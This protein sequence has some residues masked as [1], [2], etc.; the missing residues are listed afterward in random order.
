MKLKYQISEKTRQKMKEGLKKAWKDGK[1][2]NVDWKAS[3]K[4]G[5]KKRIKTLNKHSVKNKISDSVTEAWKNG[6][7]SKRKSFFKKGDKHPFYNPD[8][9]KNIKNTVRKN[10]KACHFCS[11]PASIVHRLNPS[12][13]YT[14]ENC[15][16]LCRQCHI[17]LH[18]ILRHL[19]IKGYKA[20]ENLMICYKKT[21]EGEFNGLGKN[22]KD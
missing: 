4:K 3:S 17:A 16:S 19:R 10:H 1:Y 8:S 12:G 6:K 11:K 5:N 9:K 20:H 7:F 2:D 14:E 15:I 21:I 13:K 18:T 22:K